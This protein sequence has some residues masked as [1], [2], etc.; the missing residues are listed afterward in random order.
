[1][2]VAAT[3]L[4]APEDY[5]QLLSETRPVLWNY[6]W[7]FFVDPSRFDAGDT[8]AIAGGL[9]E[10]QLNLGAGSRGPID[11]PR[12]TTSLEALFNRFEGQRAVTV[13]SL[14]LVGAGLAVL[15]LSLIGK[16]PTC[17]F[18]IVLAR[19]FPP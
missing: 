7:R 5:R 17:A 18:F 19:A 3:A 8:A 13:A 9:Q 2:I 11:E 16:T 1:M 4:V 6:G 12:L 14:S 15:A 10:L